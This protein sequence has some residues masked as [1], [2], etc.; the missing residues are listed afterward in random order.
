[1]ELDEKKEAEEVF[2]KASEAYA[3]LSD[4]EKQKAKDKYGKKGLEAME[5]GMDPEAAGFG[6]SSGDGG[7][8]DN[9]GGGFPGGGL[10]EVVVV[11]FTRLIEATLMPFACL[12]KKI[13][14]G[15][16]GGFG[17]GGAGGGFPGGGFGGRAQQQQQQQQA[18]ATTRA[19]SK[20]QTIARLGKLIPSQS[21]HGWWCFIPTI[22]KRVHRRNLFWNSWPKRSRSRWEL[23]I[24]DKM[25]GRHSFERT[26]ESRRTM[27]RD[28]HWL[29][30]TS[31]HVP[32]GGSGKYL[33]PR[34]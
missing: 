16:G 21:I 8:F 14:G 10:K 3:V 24:V 15:R 34:K 25:N 18:A 26:G 11:P 2:I 13:S 27:C 17:G 9:G 31:S 12:K 23:S 6:R 1:V 5:R 32:N 33:Q 30:I 4:K 22:H 7:A 20:G 19:L 28:L 29:S